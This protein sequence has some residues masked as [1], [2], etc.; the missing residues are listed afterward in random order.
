MKLRL[1]IALVIVAFSLLTHFLNRS[2]NPITG[3][4]QS[5]GGITEEMEVQM[6]LQAA[7]EMARQFGG[8]SRRADWT[9]R[10]EEMGARL[11]NSLYQKLQKE[12]RQLPWT[13]DFHL[14]ADGEVVNAFALPGGQVFLTEAIYRDF[15][16]PGQLAGVLG[17]EIGH[18][19]ERHGAQRIAQQQLM[20][21]IGSAAGVAS[22][23]MNT[24]RAA[25]AV[26]GMVTMKYGRQDELE[27]D[28]WGVELMVLSG[29]H[30]EHMLEVMDILEKAGGGADPPEFLS[31]HPR[32]AHRREYI[33]RIIAELFP[34]GIPDGL[35]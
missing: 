10:V 26:L 9:A 35:K 29:F 16:H 23:D 25:Q 32:P 1:I 11:V 34:N 14:L 20:Q 22:G 3:E 27:S 15:T 5:V 19:L 28:R 7:P 33:H 13:F 12:G 30:P 2:E 18:V 4:R 17:H 21:G 31:T 24:T 8:L 6:G